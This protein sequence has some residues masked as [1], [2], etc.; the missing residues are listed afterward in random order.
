ML[1]G[2]F[3]ELF[4]RTKGLSRRFN[5]RGGRVEAT[6]GPGRYYFG[7][8]CYVMKDSI[9]HGVWGKAGWKDGVHDTP[10]GTFAVAGT[11]WGDGLYKGS[12]G[13][14]YGVDAGVLGIVPESLWKVDDLEA[15]SEGKVID[16]QTELTFIAIDGVFSVTADGSS[17][18]VDTSEEDEEEEGWD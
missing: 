4:E 17:F 10:E 3:N 9:Y 6:F 18:A 5:E 14:E 13:R 15:D 7:D 16:V 1:E 2:H 11:A 12:D 8:I